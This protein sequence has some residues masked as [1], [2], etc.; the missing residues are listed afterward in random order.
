MIQQ[1]QRT[2]SYYWLFFVIFLFQIGCSLNENAPT[3]AMDID[4]QPFIEMARSEVCADISNK[5]FLIDN[6][7]VLWDHSGNCSDA[8]YAAILYKETIEE[9]VCSHYDSIAGP[10]F[11]C[12]PAYEEI[13]QTI[14]QNLEKSDLG[15]GDDH[16]VE[17]ISF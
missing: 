16:V 12:E 2:R 8:G 6:E 4:L 11:S 1:F 14:L 7:L 10:Q 5:L 9:V 3:A 15:L 13:F 17:E